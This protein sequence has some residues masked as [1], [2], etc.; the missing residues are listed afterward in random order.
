MTVSECSIKFSE[1]SRHVPTLVSTVRERVR[2]F[3]EGI[4]Y[5]I[6]FTLACE[7]VTDT[8]YQHVVEI[9]QRLEGMWGRERED[10]EAKR[11]RDSGGYSGARTPAA[12]HHGRGY[13]RHPVYSTLPASSGALAI[14]RSQVSHFAHPLS[15]APQA[16]SAF[17]GQST[18][19]CQSQY[20]QPRPPRAYFECGDTRY[21]VRDCRRLRRGAPPQT[22]QA[23]RIPPGQQISQAMVATPVAAPPAQP[24]RGG[25]RR[26]EVTLEWEANL[27]SM[28]FRDG[29]V[30]AYASWQFKVHEKN[31]PVH[32]WELAAIVHALKIWRHYL[33]PTVVVLYSSECLYDVSGFEEALLVEENEERYSGVCV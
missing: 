32:D 12:A 24:A 30:I 26:V 28:R 33:K 11:P 25:V 31:Y 19:P 7:L 5:G 10:R 9:A 20:Q 27:D 15:S 17:S 3:I 1:L 13:V 16:R 8:L 6:R 2:R 14:S 18:R 23:P 21:M 22:T 29:R 4:N